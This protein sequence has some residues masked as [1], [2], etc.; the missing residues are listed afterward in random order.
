MRGK[1]LVGKDI[2][3]GEGGFEEALEGEAEFGAEDGGGDETLFGHGVRADG[4]FAEEVLGGVGVEGEGGFEVG[5]LDAG[6]EVLLEA[7]VEGDGFDEAG[8]GFVLGDEVGAEAAADLF[9]EFVR[10]FRDRGVVG[11]GLEDEREV[12]DRHA[13]AEEVLEDALDDAEV[14]EIGE[15]FGDEGGV[16]FLDAVD[17]ALDLLAAEDEVGD[18]FEGFGE[19]G[20]EDGDG[21]DDAVA[22]DFGGAFLFFRD[23]DGFDVEDGFAGGD[24]FE[25][26][27]GAGD[28]HGEPAVRYDAGAGDGLST[29]EEAVFVRFEF[30][31][32]ADGDGRDDHAVVAGK[33]F[34]DAGDAV[35]EFAALGFV[36]EAEEAVADFDREHF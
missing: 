1:F 21:I 7:G 4:E 32:V 36:R 28:I 15:E 9:G 5:A 22:V 24:A 31:A 17:E 14:D 23:P 19:V 6:D 35:E 2:E 8:F 26:D 11:D 10:V 16:G 3:F 25:G 33:A 13:F 20:D 27:V 29:E 12:F 30:E 18:L 34:A